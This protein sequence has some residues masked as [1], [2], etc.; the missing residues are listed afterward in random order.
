[1]IQITGLTKAYRR[2]RPPA[3]LDLT[4]DARPGMVTALLGDEGAG[5]STA[6]RLMVELERGHGLTLFDGRTYRRIRRPER[7]IGVLL[8]AGRPEAG[9]PGQRARA[10][11][12][13]LAG[14]VGVPARRADDLLE[15]TRLAAVADHRIGTFSPGM[16]RRL[17]LAAA[18]LGTPSTLL[19]DAPTEGL[20]PSNEEWFG[21]FLR[22]FALSGGTVLTTTRSPAEAAALADRVVTLDAG[23]LAADQPV[24]EFRR[25]RLHPEVLVRG[26]QMARLADLLVAQGGQVRRDGGAGL[27]VS[28]IDRTEVGE[29]AYRNGILLHELADRVA[30]RPVS[31][32]AA[33]PG[34]SGRSGQVSIRTPRQNP[35]QQ[36]QS[37]SG[38]TA[39]PAGAS[40]LRAD[41]ADGPGAAHPGADHPGA[42]APGEQRSGEQR[43]ATVGRPAGPEPERPL[44]HRGLQAGRWATAALAPNPPAPAQAEPRTP[45]VSVP[46]PTAPAQTAPVP[47]AFPVDLTRRTPR[48]ASA[49]GRPAA[50]AAPATAAAVPAAV[51]PEPGPAAVDTAAVDTEQLAANPTDAELLTPA[52]IRGVGQRPAAPVRPFPGRPWSAA[53]AELRPAGRAEPAE[54]SRSADEVRPGGAGAVDP[55]GAAR[56][57]AVGDENGSE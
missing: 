21:A 43:P 41:G 19:L 51:E 22:S 11:L 33:L 40:G 4:F 45:A 27:A 14:A 50:T 35:Q 48:G 31:Y 30:E 20:S 38:R 5:K 23:R 53:T 32:P 3:V 9:H 34:S 7:E 26:P 6:L 25:T 42:P 2:G 18:L 13:M 1:M 29:L 49:L 39:Q 24:V 12:R 36:P 37:Q 46:A 55:Q 28:G 54:R 15:Q 8:A 47:P 56:R 57:G 17:A 44:D 10:H 16:H 52:R